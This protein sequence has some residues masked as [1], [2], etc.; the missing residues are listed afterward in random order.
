MADQ[1]IH[2]HDD[3]ST[4]TTMGWMWFVCHCWSPINSERARK[5]EREEKERH[6]NINYKWY[7]INLWWVE[8]L[9]EFEWNISS[10][11]NR[12]QNI[13]AFWSMK[14]EIGINFRRAFFPFQANCVLIESTRSVHF[15]AAQI[16]KKQSKFFNSHFTS[17]HNLRSE[18]QITHK[19]VM[20]AIA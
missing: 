6:I 7:F 9:L 20:T 18:I 2:E 19:T 5:W 14:S 1:R 11:S 3:R 8:F 4:F 15:D 12:I 10:G 16:S 13:E 17:V